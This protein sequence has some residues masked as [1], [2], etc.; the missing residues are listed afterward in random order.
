M[1]TTKTHN[2]KEWD[3]L[4]NNGPFPLKKL[5]I[6]ELEGD[7]NMPDKIDRFNDAANEI[8][9][10]IKETKDANQG[11]RAYGSAWS[12]NHIASHKDRMHYN[13]FMN[14]HIPIIPENCHTNSNFDASNLFLFECG[15]T[16]KRVSEVLSAHG[17]SLKTTGASNGQTIA[18]CISTGVHGSAFQVGA[19]QDYVVG[20]NLIIGPN[21]NDVVYLERHTQPALNDAFAKKIS[22]KI[23]RNDHLFNAALVGLG[24]FGFV[25]GIVI[26]AEPRFLLKRYVKKIN[27]DVVLKL[28]DTLDFKNSTFKIP[29]ETT[30][31]GF[32]ITPYHYKVFI[33]QYSKEPEYVIELMY[34]KPFKTDYKDPFPIIKQSL[35]RDLIHLF[36]KLAEKLPK[37][38]P[39]LVKQLR[40]T[41]MPTVD[42]ELTGTLPEIFWDAPYQGPAFACSVGVDHKDSSKALKLLADLTNNEGPIPGIFA[43]RFVKQTKATLGFT[44]FPVTCMLEID[45]VLWKKTRKIMSLT[46]YSKRIIEVL[47]QNNIP[48]TIHWGKNSDWSFPGLVNHMYGADS[49]NTWNS[50]RKALLGDEMMEMFSNDFLHDTG[51][52]KKDMTMDDTD[53]NLIASL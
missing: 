11:F 23:I 12:M 37:S 1:A 7:G 33:N 38:I 49:V 29:E 14:I 46:E 30:A 35:Y 5:Y 31:D 26:E 15:T 24:G 39:W 47:K 20:L 10:L 2:L 48:F 16:I 22:A 27:K 34:K 8:R 50:Y 18:G 44:K 25:H 41:I 40:K 43:M 28:A 6:T 45:G 13:G 32:G 53:E 21:P 19:V 9:R 42:D 51:L 3:T 52:A 36:T 4:H 17:K